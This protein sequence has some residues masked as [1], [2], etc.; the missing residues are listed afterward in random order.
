MN[1]TKQKRETG[2]ENAAAVDADAYG[3]KAFSIGS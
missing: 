3:H 1:K 2:E